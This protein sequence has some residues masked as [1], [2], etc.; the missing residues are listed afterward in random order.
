MSERPR[1]VVFLSAARTPIGR[2]QG[3]LSSLPAARLGAAVIQAAVQ[4]AGLADLAAI[5]KLLIAVSQMAL[6]LPEISEMDL[7]PAMVYPQGQGIKIV[8][9]RIK[10]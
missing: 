3:S 4:R 2:F 6:D 5:E 7:N 1:D 10:K 9:V 8:D